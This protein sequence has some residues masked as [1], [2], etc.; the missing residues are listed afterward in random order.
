MIS[1]F[2]GESVVVG[3]LERSSG[4]GE[5]CCEDVC[6]SNSWRR[7][8]RSTE[9]LVELLLESRWEEVKGGLLVG[10][11]AL[12]SVGSV[13]GGVLI[14]AETLSLFWFLFSGV[15]VLVELFV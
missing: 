14:V 8:L 4:G 2:V 1:L 10:V 6:S 11:E 3:V 15:T 13:V 7:R 12:W 9:S 5:L